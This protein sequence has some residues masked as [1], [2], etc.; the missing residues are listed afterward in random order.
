MTITYR[1]NWGYPERSFDLEEFR[2]D[3]D[4]E[5]S[6]YGCQV[7]AWDDDPSDAWYMHMKYYR[8][9]STYH[10]SDGRGYIRAKHCA[11]LPENVYP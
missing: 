8:V 10:V 5:F 2:S 7:L 9:N 4:R 6:G 1:D 3:Y 11:F